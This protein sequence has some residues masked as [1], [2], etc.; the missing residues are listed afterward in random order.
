[1]LPNHNLVFLVIILRE[2]KYKRLP[3]IVKKKLE[4]VLVQER[5]YCLNPLSL[6]NQAICPKETTLLKQELGV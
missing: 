6:T 5:L 2:P 4:G 1:M 3:D